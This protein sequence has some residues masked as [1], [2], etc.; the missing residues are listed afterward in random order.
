M[1]DP[2]DKAANKYS[3][4]EAKSHFSEILSRVEGGQDVL[5]TR[6]GQPVARLSGVEP[7]RQAPRWE[8]IDSFRNSLAPAEES[9]ESLI[10]RLRDD[11]RL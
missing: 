4:A 2:C 6:R 1:N 11:A 8:A 7:V 9:S 10:R 5:I 3:V